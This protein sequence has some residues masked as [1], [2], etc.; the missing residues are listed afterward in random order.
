MANFSNR[1]LD[2]LSNCHP[3]L[4]KIHL[5]FISRS[6]VDYGINCGH[7]PSEIQ[8]ELFKKGRS[9]INNKWVVT[10]KS[11]VVTN[12]DGYTIKGEHNIFPSNATDFY[13]YVPGFKT[14]AY[15]KVHLTYIASGLVLT[16]QML[17][18]AGEIEHLLKWGGNWDMDGILLKDQ[19]LQDLCHV[20]LY[21]P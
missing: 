7:R 5:E 19:T 2:N 10:D 3:D 16:A 6:R 14:L 12:I 20:Q 18:E 17:F 13:A 15:D 11:K 9:F 4:I 8:F 21:K 1:S